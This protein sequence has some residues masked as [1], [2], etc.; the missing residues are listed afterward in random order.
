MS[1]RFPLTRVGLFWRV[2]LFGIALILLVTLVTALTVDVTRRRTP[3][4]AEAMEFGEQLQAL[5]PGILS[6]PASL[7]E[8]PK[9]EAERTGVE[10]SVFWPDAGWVAR[11][12]EC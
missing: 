5:G 7:D 10:A 4:F 12:L 9:R 8:R 2:Y 1:G 6:D 3:P 11:R